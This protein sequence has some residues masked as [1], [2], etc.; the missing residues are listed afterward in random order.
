MN[1]TLIGAS[2]ARLE[3]SDKVTGQ[4]L[5]IDDLRFPN[6]LVGRTLRS[7]HPHARIIAVHTEAALAVRGVRTVVTGRDFPKKYGLMIPDETV[8]AVDKVRYIG[9]EVAA[10]AAETEEAAEEAL[11]AITVDYELLP[12]IFDPEAAMQDDAPLVHE[13]VSRNVRIEYHIERGDVQTA[14]AASDCIIEQR[15]KTQMQHQGYMEPYSCVVSPEGGRLT[16]WAPVQ[17]PFTLADQLSGVFG[18]SAT[19]IRVIQTNIGGAYG[20]KV[21]YQRLNYVTAL[22]AQRAG[23]P[24]RIVNK[25]WEEFA[26]GRPRIPVI[27]DMKMGFD[28]DGKILAKQTR[29][30]ADNGACC[31]FTPGILPVL[32]MRHE[33]Q[34]RI[35]D[36]HTDSYLV[37]T[38]KVPTGPFRGFG[39]IQMIFALE[40]MMDMAARRL[41]V[42]PI[43]IRLRNV[44]HA[45]DVTVHG[46]EIQTDGLTRCLEAVRERMGSTRGQRKPNHGFGFSCAI[47]SSS[48][49]TRPFDGTTAR[50]RLNP[51]GTV[52]VVT[53]D[54]DLGQG[55]R[56]IY[57]QI[58]ASELEIPIEQLA[59]PLVDTDFSPYGLGTYADRLTTMGGHSARGAARELKQKILEEAAS[60]LEAKKDDLEYRDG[61]V[62]YRGHPEKALTISEIA[63]RLL[64]RLGGKVLTVE[65]TYDPPNTVQRD[66]Q[67]LM[68]N[69][70][71][72]HSFSA[73]GVEVKVDETTGE[74]NVLRVVSAHDLGKAIN[75]QSCEGQIE[76]AVSIGIGYA[77]SEGYQFD[78]GQP[79]TNTFKDYGIP[80]ATDIP[81]I[82]TVLVE[83]NDP[84]GPYGAKGVGQTGTLLPAPAIANALEDAVGVRLTELPMNPD[85]VLEG[86]LKKQRLDNNCRKTGT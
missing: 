33:N 37:Y 64:W 71:S 30:V 27:A 42:D 5:Y 43:E 48:N 1:K 34:Y 35:S 21:S 68:G 19:R 73:Q 20:G 63:K 67:T 70:H 38:N 31:G 3:S 72:T 55:S 6:V 81:R 66:P 12:A 36:I 26:A 78:G 7:P 54:P 77:L 11:N 9:D 75:P 41:G 8:L 59:V 50:L 25:R 56:T 45:G 4:A 61:S 28:R 10:V 76:G 85:R 40:S 57:A 74:I 49:R 60:L 24:V 2:T 82:E 18:L 51:D 44:V 47:H 52:H 46:Y 79:L 15:F 58:V 62:F 29:L 39:N 14:F 16:V 53:S 83:T 17:D 32:T 65:Y 13:D 80:R 22:L 23:Q 84:M 86:I 69:T